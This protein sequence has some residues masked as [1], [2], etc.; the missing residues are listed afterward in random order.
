MEIVRHFE[1]SRKCD[2]QETYGKNIKSMLINK[3]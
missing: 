1:D 3:Y 2:P